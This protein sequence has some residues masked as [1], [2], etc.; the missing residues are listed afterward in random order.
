MTVESETGR[1]IVSIREGIDWP[2]IERVASRFTGANRVGVVLVCRRLGSS[3]VQQCTA[4]G[5]ARRGLARAPG[6]HPAGPILEPNEFIVN[7]TQ[8]AS[9]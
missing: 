8:R 1:K 7:F 2:R 3:A 4:C 9:L 5:G 6:P